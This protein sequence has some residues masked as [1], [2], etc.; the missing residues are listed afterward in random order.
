MS[1]TPERIKSKTAENLRTLFIAVGILFVLIAW[2]LLSGGS[3][4]AGLIFSLLAILLLWIA[5]KIR[6]Y[7]D[8]V[9]ESAIYR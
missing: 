5:T 4:G 6:V 7:K 1:R 8:K 9:L 2:G 3:I